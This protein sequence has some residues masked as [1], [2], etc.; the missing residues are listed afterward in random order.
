MGVCFFVFESSGR[1][2]STFWRVR[3]DSR[4]GVYPWGGVGRGGSVGGMRLD[5]VD[6]AESVASVDSVDSSVVGLGVA[7]F[8]VFVDLV[9]LG[10]SMGFVGSVAEVGEVC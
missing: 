1:Y 9:A 8:S 2:L 7:N 10:V 6:S 5:I 3:V 4:R